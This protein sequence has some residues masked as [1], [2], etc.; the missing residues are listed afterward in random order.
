MGESAPGL[1]VLLGKVLRTGGN[2][3]SFYAAKERFPSWIEFVSPAVG[4]F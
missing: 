1:E 2:Q 4:M 3:G